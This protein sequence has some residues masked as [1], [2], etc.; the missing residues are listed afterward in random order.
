MPPYL[1]SSCQS[2]YFRYLVHSITVS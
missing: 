2:C 1:V